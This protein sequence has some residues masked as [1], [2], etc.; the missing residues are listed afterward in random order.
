MSK[1]ILE[2]GSWMDRKILSASEK[3]CLSA[4]VAASSHWRS[5]SRKDMV[6][7]LGNNELLAKFEEA[8]LICTSEVRKC[9]DSFN[10]S[11]FISA[12]PPDVEIQQPIRL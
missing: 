4:Q 8:F 2:F 12:P 3:S 1:Q 7:G 5:V 6:A 10:V 11:T 9:D